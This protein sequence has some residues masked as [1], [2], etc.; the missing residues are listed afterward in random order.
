[1]NIHYT[2]QRR[3]RALIQASFVGLIGL[4]V[5]YRLLFWLS[6][7]HHGHRAYQIAPSHDWPSLWLYL[8][9]IIGALLVYTA[10]QLAHQK[11]RARIAALILLPS[12]A[13]CALCGHLPAVG[14]TLA[15]L[16]M[17]VWLALSPNIY[18]AR[19]DVTSARAGLKVSGILLAATFVFGVAGLLLIGTSA[20]HQ[21]YDLISAA[22]DI[23]QDMLTIG[24]SP[25]LTPTKQA[26][27]FVATLSAM[28]FSLIVVAVLA[29]FRPVRFHL[30]N[31]ARD[32]QHMEE[33]M[34]KYS[35]SPDDYFKLWPRDKWYYF[36][37][38]GE[39]GL[40][41]GLSGSSAV[42]LGTPVGAAEKAHGLVAE[43]MEFCHG[44]GWQVGFLQLT[45]NEARTYAVNGLSRVLL[46]NEAVVPLDAF[47]R[48]TSQSKHFRYVR[49]KAARDGL[50]VEFW[51][52]PTP[53]QL[54]QLR[55]ISDEWL[56]AG[57]RREYTFFMGYF[58][59]K[60]LSGCRVAV[61][62]Q[63][64]KPVAYTNLTPLYQSTSSSI[65]HMRSTADA[66]PVA[67]HFLLHSVAL[68]QHE[69]GFSSLSLGLSPLSTM[70][71]DSSRA[72]RLLTL[73]KK[74]G[75][76]YYSFDGLCQFKNKFKPEWQPLYLCY[77]RAGQLP[78]IAHGTNR[79]STYMPRLNERQRTIVLIGAVVLLWVFIQVINVLF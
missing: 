71:G 12:L 76:S 69:K 6:L 19:S 78:L 46:G 31:P 27:I 79:L 13:L 77:E 7:P 26:K 22:S 49:N 73:L 68:D 65:D 43:F 25:L 57:E 55:Q 72:A 42:V 63:Q 15:A 33:L 24:D 2:M 18:T 1:V 8:S 4:A 30:H 21:Q 62:L 60:Y 3:R 52:H 23:A 64:G 16:A 17:T 41:Y 51:Q 37:S 70:P 28:E 75:K 66:S 54:Q 58:D 20:F 40:A 59:E 34:K 32:I 9:T 47:V 61:V 29:F 53:S 10:Y 35:Q 74:F 5:S 45:Q 67:M 38:T 56:E 36:D 11:S 44:N 39:C 48:T 14:I 50:T